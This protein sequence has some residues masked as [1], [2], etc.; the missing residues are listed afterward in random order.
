MYT[1]TLPSRVPTR[2]VGYDN[3]DAL[4]VG[5]KRASEG[6]TLRLCADRLLLLFLLLLLSLL[7]ISLHQRNAVTGHSS[8]KGGMLLCLHSVNVSCI[9][10]VDGLA[11]VTNE[12]TLC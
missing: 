7:L 2:M 11:C 8:D 6:I 1:D 3:L 10:M 9:T 5:V 4:F 12:M